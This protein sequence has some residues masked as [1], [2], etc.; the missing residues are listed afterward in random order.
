MRAPDSSQDLGGQADQP[1]NHACR[2]RCLLT[3]ASVRPFPLEQPR[4]SHLWVD[5]QDDSAVAEGGGGNATA[6]F[7]SRGDISA[8]LCVQANAAIHFSSGGGTDGPPSVLQKAL[9]ATHP[10]CLYVRIHATTPLH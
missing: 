9:T 8:T 1:R 7:R 6:D 2:T 5:T 10:H 3:A 4:Q